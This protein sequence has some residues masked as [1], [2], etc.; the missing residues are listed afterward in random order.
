MPSHMDSCRNLIERTEPMQRIGDMTVSRR[1][2]PTMPLRL[3]L[4]GLGVLLLTTWAA[5][6]DDGLKKIDEMPIPTAEELLTK[7]PV[8]WIVLRPPRRDEVLVVQPVSPRPD[9]IARMAKQLED[10]KSSAR[11]PKQEQGESND[12]YR[13][14]IRQL[15]DEA[16]NLLILLPEPPKA[17][18]MPDE[19][20]DPNEPKPAAQPMPDP[21]NPNA[22]MPMKTDDSGK[23]FK[24]NVAKN[25]E[26]IVYH[27][28]LMLKRADILMNE[29]KLGPAFEML[30]VLE[31][32]YSD[33][34]GY[35]DRR[36]RLIFEEAKMQTAAG[37]VEAA[38][39]YFEELH[40]IAPAYA[41]LR[42]EMGVAANAL[43]EGAYNK[44]ELMRARFYL[45]RL[46]K[47]DPEHP[48]AVKWTSTFTKRV[49]EL[50]DKAKSAREQG[51]HAEALAMVEEA[52]RV[53]PIH[54]QLRNFHRAVANRYQVL[55]V[56]V[57]RFAGDAGPFPFPAQ[58]EK[59]QEAL[60][61]VDLFEVSKVDRNPFYQ[62]RFVEEWTP[63]D[64]GRQ[65]VFN[66]RPRRSNWEANPVISA[67]QVAG[68]LAARLDR[69]SPLYDERFS[70]YVRSLTVKSP[71]E[72]VVNLSTIPVR[73]QAI[74]R[75]PVS[76]NATTVA[77]PDEAATD[78]S[79]WIAS[80][81]F[82]LVE[83]SADRQVYRRSMPEAETSPQ[84][85]VAEVIEKKY[86]THEAAV[87]GLL[88]GD[89]SVYPSPPIWLAGRIA[90]SDEFQ[91]EPFSIPTTHVLQ[92][93]AR[94]E[95]LKNNEFR[96]ALGYA[97]NRD[98][99]LRETMFRNEKSVETRARLT[100]AVFP[101]KSY[102]YNATV[103]QTKYDIQLAFA[104]V[105][106]SK[107]R[108][109]GTIPELTMICEPDESIIRCAEEFVKDWARVG[110]KVNLISDPKAAPPEQ[111]DIA[112]RTAKM[113]EP[114]TELWPFLTMSRDARVNDLEHLPDW[115]RQ[116]LIELEQAP[117]SNAAI[118]MLRRLHFRLS[119]FQLCVPLWEIDDVMVIRK[120]I[121]GMPSGPL[122]PYHNLERWIVQPWFPTDSLGEST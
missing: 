101:S 42:Q 65:I 25:V 78:P 71:T 18:P 19:G 121:L 93:N 69:Q 100:T 105:T 120:N 48:I 57:V 75:F 73:P 55:N 33:W 9:T 7:P 51:K 23:E 67:S 108:L 85:H 46:R 119:E 13:E 47:R 114:L 37:N 94:S 91:I 116:Q 77:S 113:A 81:R 82:K 4:C 98:R 80:S 16:E 66:L 45:L 52:S 56:G 53:W 107:K 79:A 43:I 3:L 68:T 12:Q 92:F 27:E 72:F 24:L 30:L 118:D 35:T 40:A 112:Y 97:I 44:A 87:Q 99:I 70:N 28:D 22:P 1:I 39:A 95:P 102:A 14:R 21:N 86:P 109:G 60:T 32:R 115:L 20:A 122:H 6:Q 5:A 59:R 34:P 63:T 29:G 17:A 106:V 58:E 49:D 76:S 10:L 61:A 90:T 54:P 38:F 111:W 8:D 2:A 50:L 88:R 110:V 96:R 36:N 103:E 89:I 41:G 26:R 83:K 62:S 104:L 117:D 74:F 31:R 11:R 84:F 15:M 64:L